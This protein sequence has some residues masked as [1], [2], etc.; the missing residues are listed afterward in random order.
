MESQAPAERV[1]IIATPQVIIVDD[2]REDRL[3]ARRWMH[4]IREDIDLSE[5]KKAS[6]FLAHITKNPEQN[7]TLILLDINIPPNSG[8]DVLQEIKAKALLPDTPIVMFTTS[9]R[10]EDRELCVVSG[11]SDY[12]VK[13]STRHE[14]TICIEK[15]SNYL[16]APRL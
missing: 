8:I 3:L 14:R 1:D 15:L 12:I 9:N 16:L 11:A 2:D 10:R 4:S 7:Y 13:P 6:D 5:F